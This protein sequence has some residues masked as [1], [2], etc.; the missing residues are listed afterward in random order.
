MDNIA[1]RSNPALRTIGLKK[2][3]WPAGL[4]LLGSTRSR[5]QSDG[6][7]VL[8]VSVELRTIFTGVSSRLDG[9]SSD[10]YTSE[11]CWVPWDS[12]EP[13][14]LHLVKVV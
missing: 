11:R 10:W 2:P 1:T 8:F 12:L 7:E 5:V 9:Y 6:T 14:E 4:C 3:L 13:G